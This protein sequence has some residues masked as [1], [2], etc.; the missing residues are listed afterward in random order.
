MVEPNVKQKKQFSF[1][2]IIGIIFTF[3]FGY[4]LISGVL[5]VTF[6]IKTPDPFY[7]TKPFATIM[8]DPHSDLP[9]DKVVSP[10]SIQ[11]LLDTH[12]Y[13]YIYREGVFDCSDM[14][15]EDARLLNSLGYHTSVIG[16]DK[17]E[18]AWVFVWA[19]KNSGWAIES[20]SVS[21]IK[22]NSGEVVGDDWYDFHF[23]FENLFEKNI[24]ELYYPSIERDGLHVLDWNDP[25]VNKH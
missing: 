16:D 5:G 21:E 1:R 25:E 10:T 20:T 9:Y 7:N 3:I 4:M 8:S 19:S 2:K 15:K 14:S 13:I 22:N 11:K 24:Y 23:V 6:N 12:P 17:N 18:H